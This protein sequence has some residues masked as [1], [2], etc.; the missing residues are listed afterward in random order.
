L[1]SSCAEGSSIGN[2]ASFW[3]AFR[4]DMGIGFMEPRFVGFFSGDSLYA[5]CFQIVTDVDRLD[6]LSLSWLTA[7]YL[8]TNP[9][10]LS[11]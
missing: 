11:I 10:R 4:V 8:K 2:S 7:F 5:F 6:N 3:I 1:S 9:L